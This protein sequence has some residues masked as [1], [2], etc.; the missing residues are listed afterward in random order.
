MIDPTRFPPDPYKG[1]SR[2]MFRTLGIA[3]SGLSAQRTRLDV[4]A[5]N[6]ANA[7]RPPTPTGAPYQRQVV[8][9]EARGNAWQPY[10][11]G[12]NGDP[13]AFRLPSGNPLDSMHGVSVA[14]IE[15]DGT[16]GSLVYEPGHPDADA[17]GYVRYPERPHHR[18]AGRPDGC[19]HGLRSERDR[20]PVREVDASPGARNLRGSIDEPQWSERSADARSCGRSREFPERSTERSTEGHRRSTAPSASRGGRR[21]SAGARVRTHFRWTPRRDRPGAVA[22]PD[23]SERAY[24]AKM[25]SMGP[26]TYGRQLRRRSQ[27]AGRRRTSSRAAAAST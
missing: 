11:V 15:A 17:N 12:P 16:E 26:L 13:A 8:R 23:L 10:E 4:I 20:F 7:E 24:F 9:M 6:I 1:V 25:T 3:A 2:R 19:A 22:G 14:A 18:R 21:R 27:S 5:S